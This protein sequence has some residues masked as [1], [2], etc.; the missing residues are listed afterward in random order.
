MKPSEKLK[1]LVGKGKAYRPVD[2]GVALEKIGDYADGVQQ[3]NVWRKGRGFDGNSLAAKKARRDAAKA[4]G[5]PEDHFELGADAPEASEAEVEIEGSSGATDAPGIP[6]GDID[7]AWRAGV[8]KYLGS[9]R[10]ADTPW[11]VAMALLR[12]P[13]GYLECD[14]GS[15]DEIHDLRV[16]LQGKKGPPAQETG[17][18][19][20]LDDPWSSAPLFWRAARDRNYLKHGRPEKAVDTGLAAVQHV[21]HGREPSEGEADRLFREARAS[22][23]SAL[24]PAKRNP[25]KKKAPKPKSRR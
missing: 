3:I 13:F 15:P 12:A 20:P 18:P 22:A 9:P 17:K 7:P 16:Y 11:V 19:L 8:E 5:R 21:T 10:G 23:S 6:N 1:A 14:P 2:V 4:I 24:A 25:V